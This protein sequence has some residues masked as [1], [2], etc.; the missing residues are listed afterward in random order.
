[1]TYRVD[2]PWG[3]VPSGR[4]H[5]SPHVEEKDSRDTTAVQRAGGMCGWV[6]DV[7]VGANHPHADRAGD[8]TN[9]KKLTSAQLVN[10]EKQPDKGHDGFDNAEDT[11]HNAN[12]A[13]SNT[14]ALRK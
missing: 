1:M 8:S 4:V 13:R 7:D 11:S 12:S 3:S 10:Q 6:H 5:C 2:D 14:N 9:E